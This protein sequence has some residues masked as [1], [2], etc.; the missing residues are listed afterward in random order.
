MTRRDAMF[1]YQNATVIG[2]MKNNL[3]SAMLLFNTVGLL[4]MI[5]E[6]KNIGS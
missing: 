1:E 5:V 3:K 2:D 6:R 4:R